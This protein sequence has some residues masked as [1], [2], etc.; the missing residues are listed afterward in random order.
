VFDTVEKS[1]T[2]LLEIVTLVSSVNKIIS[3]KVY[4]VGGRSFIHIMKNKSD[5]LGLHV[6]LFPILRKIS[7]IIS[8]HFSFSIC[9]IGSEAVSY[10]SL[11]VILMYLC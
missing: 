6:L 1:S 11:N 5:P 3:D 2:F 7:Q 10:C 8:F 4:I 9:Q